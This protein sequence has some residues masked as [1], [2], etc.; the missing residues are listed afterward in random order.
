MLRTD[1]VHPPACATTL[2]VGLGLLASAVEAAIVVSAVVLVAVDTVLRPAM[3]P[4]ST[5]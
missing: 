2:I 1:F 5:E 3:G 4:L